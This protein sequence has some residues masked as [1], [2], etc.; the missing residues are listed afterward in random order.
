MK[1]DFKRSDFY[2]KLNEN[3]EKQFYILVNKKWVEI[4]REV[5]LVYQNSYKKLYRDQIRD[6][7]KI[8]HYENV[9]DIQPY[10]NENVDCDPVLN[11]YMKE[12]KKELYHVLEQLD[13]DEREFIY[14]YYF[15]DVSERQLATYLNKSK[16]SIHYKKNKILKKIRDS[17]DH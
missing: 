4:N 7:E 6:R 14:L 16:T 11:V 2:T 1:N 10:L 9:D 3:N 12:I 13:K 17:I 15:F 5:Y 8:I